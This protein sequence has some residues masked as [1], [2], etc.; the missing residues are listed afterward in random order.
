MF[1]KIM[2]AKY[3]IIFKNHSNFQTNNFEKINR[4]LKEREKDIIILYQRNKTWWKENVEKFI[5]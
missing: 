3:M 2:K 4:I 5:K 1:R